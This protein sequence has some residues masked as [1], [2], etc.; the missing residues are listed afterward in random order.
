MQKLLK[1]VLAFLI[2]SGISIL[3]AEEKLIIKI[4]DKDGNVK[5]TMDETE[6]RGEV[7]NF[8]ILQGAT[9]EAAEL[10]L[11]NDM[12]RWQFAS[13]IIEQELVYMVAVEEGLDKDEDV[14]NKVTVERDRQIAQ[15][16][17]QETLNADKLKVT[18][19]EKRA[20]YKKEYNKIVAAAGRV[21]SYEQIAMDI[22]YAIAQEKM[23]A[24]YA[25]IVKESE[26]KYKIK[27]SSTQDPCIIIEET[28]VPLKDFDDMFNASLKAAGANIP[29]AMRVQAKE[30]MFIAFVAREIM[31]YE[32]KKSGFYETPQ[33]KSLEHFV[34]RNAVNMN[35]LDK[36]IRSDIKEP[37]KEE[38]NEAY[39][40]YGKVYNIDALPYAKA[41]EAL[42]TIVN[43]EKFQN[44][45]KIFI[46]NLR[47]EN[48]IEKNLEVFDKK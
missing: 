6:F 8:L 30:G 48:S 33:A 20:Y 9:G 27:Y 23:K 12:N 44:K 40:K 22:E 45:Y 5:K 47:Y 2:F 18:E 11:A 35:Y 14:L 34:K 26:K 41:Q 36:K 1:A 43:E 3:N 28:K 19:E 15:L 42:K 31:T 10:I 46:Q 16:Y 13:Q 37:T 7:S 32:A 21:V 24:E 39:K 4:T 25:R 17:A 29:A 38:I